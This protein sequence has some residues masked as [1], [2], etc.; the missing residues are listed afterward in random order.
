MRRFSIVLS[1]ML[2]ALALSANGAI[3]KNGGGAKAGKVKFK[4]FSITKNSDKGSAI[5]LQSAGKAGG[6]AKS[7]NKAGSTIERRAK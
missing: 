4:E 2:V 3:A 7:G 1:S 5:F 6:G